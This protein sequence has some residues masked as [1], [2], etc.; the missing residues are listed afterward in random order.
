MT[1][2]FFAEAT[3]RLYV[4]PLPNLTKIL[5]LTRE[6]NQTLAEAGDINSEIAEFS[7]YYVY[8]ACGILLMASLQVS[9]TFEHDDVMR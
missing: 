6:F 8:L 1:F 9:N 3:F 2:C 7:L 5:C 4:L